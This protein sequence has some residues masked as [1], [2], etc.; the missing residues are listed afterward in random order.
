MTVQAVV[1]DI[2]NVLI[3]WEPETY[4][5]ALM[6][7]ERRRAMFEAVDLHAMNDRIDA[8]ED[9]RG[10]VEAC[11][12]ANPDFAAEIRHWHDRWL[13]FIMGEIDGSVAILRAL[14]AS[15]MPVHALS[16]FG[17]APCVLAEPRHPVLG[18][19]DVR[20]LS[21]A[22]GVTKPAPEIYAAL[23]RETGL[24][25]PALFFTDDK[26]ENIDAAAARGWQTHLFVEPQGLAEA[27]RAA[28]VPQATLDQAGSRES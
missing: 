20:L 24:A 2:G 22:V 8:G 26:P 16:N 12:A 13:D 18:E 4:Y 21:G 15:G 25:G 5:D 19:F 14:R 11:A 1:F 7:P 27:L 9:F 17:L 3:R 23:E 10:T 28:G 6:G